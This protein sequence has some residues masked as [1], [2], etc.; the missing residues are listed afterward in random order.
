[1]AKATAA[2]RDTYL[3]LQSDLEGYQDIVSALA[4]EFDLNRS[5]V[6][7][8]ATA[9]AR[10]QRLTPLL[11][12]RPEQREVTPATRGEAGKNPRIST[13]SRLGRG[14]DRCRWASRRAA[15]ERGE[16]GRSGRRAGGIRGG[17]AREQEGEPCGAGPAS[18][19]VIGCTVQLLFCVNL[20]VKHVVYNK[21]R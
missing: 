2:E 14:L 18:P 21:G 20:F 7:V 11:F 4:Q 10:M 1:L 17:E 16:R 8:R 3:A 13:A 5:H 12:S 6:Y 15:E 19:I 9:R